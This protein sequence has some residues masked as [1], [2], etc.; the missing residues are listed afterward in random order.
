MFAPSATPVAVVERL[1]A[2][3]VKAI[4]APEIREFMAREG[5]QPVGSAPQEFTAYLRAEIAR[6]RKVVETGKLRLD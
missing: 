1:H 2:E 3:I 5:A 6:Y 4:N